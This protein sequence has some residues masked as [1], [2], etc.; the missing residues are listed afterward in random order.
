M[1]FLN[2][3]EWLQSNHESFWNQTAAAV[4]GSYAVAR[5]A[6]PNAET[7]SLA[8]SNCSNDHRRRTGGH[9]DRAGSR[10]SSA[11]REC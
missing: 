9:L 8:P 1:Q 3:M 10:R 4:S 5:D 7:I 6:Q 2:R 11:A